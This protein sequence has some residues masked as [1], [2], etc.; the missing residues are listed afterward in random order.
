VKIPV[1]AYITIHSWKLNDKEKQR[2]LEQE[3]LSP[4]SSHIHTH[5][6]C[7]SS[8]WPPTSV[9]RNFGNN[10]VYRSSPENHYTSYITHFVKFSNLL[11]GS[12]V[13]LGTMLQAGRSRFPFP[14]RSLDFSIN[15]ILPVALWPWSRLSLWQKW[16]PGIFLGVKGGRRVRLTTSPPSVSRL[17][18][19]SGNLDVWQP[20]GPSGIALPYL[21]DTGYPDLDIFLSTSRKMA[22]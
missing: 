18:T 10:E 6:H 20:Y 16:V 17:P 5:T 3:I 19:K 9:T 13:G 11:R 15:L 21:H 2:L 12:V 14:T 7:Q 8:L 4:F 1:R 22:G